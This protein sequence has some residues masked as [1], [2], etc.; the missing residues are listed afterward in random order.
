MMRTRGIIQSYNGRFG[1]IFDIQRTIVDFESADFSDEK[2]VA[3]GE[4]VE[5]RKETRLDGELY[6]ARNIKVLSKSRKENTRV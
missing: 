3:L 5:F 1:T 2:D 4:E 6:I